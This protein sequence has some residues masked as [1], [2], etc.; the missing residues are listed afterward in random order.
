M[1][2]RSGTTARASAEFIQTASKTTKHSVEKHSAL[3]G[4]SYLL[5]AIGTP[6][7]YKAWSHFEATRDVTLQNA[8][9]NHYAY[10]ATAKANYYI[11]K[12][13][14]RP[15][16]EPDDVRNDAA[17]GLTE[18]IRK[19]DLSKDCKFNT[20]ATPVI[21]GRIIDGIRKL[22]TFTRYLSK[23]RREIAPLIEQLWFELEREPTQEELLARFPDF[24]VGGFFGEPLC[25]VLPDPLLTAA[26]FNQQLLLPNTEDN[27]P[28][29]GLFDTTTLRSNHELT[30][31]Q[32]LQ[33][34]D[35]W[36][37]ILKYLAPD[38]E[39][40]AVIYRYYFM[41]MTSDDVGRT[42]S[43][44]RSSTWVSSK[45]KEGLRLLR[46]AMRVDEEFEDDITE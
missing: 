14:Y 32:S 39:V 1:L 45:K 42:F 8:L 43:P 22:Q 5:N 3:N 25:N 36:V 46:K 33:K 27:E 12:L 24:Q 23:V 31:Q 26:V 40:A 13:P 44:N 30:P 16:V 11:S 9:F 35:L 6:N 28:A 37:K 17:F 15:L 18:A 7:E 34:R 2:A 10:I 21:K 38:P 19:Y 41:E 4:H 29:D 20:Y